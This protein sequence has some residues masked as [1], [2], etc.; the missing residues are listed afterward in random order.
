[1]L[2]G[3]AEA[4][5]KLLDTRRVDDRTLRLRFLP[6][7]LELLQ[8]WIHPTG[9]YDIALYTRLL[10]F[11][12]DEAGDGDEQYLVA[13]GRRTAEH[14]I[15]AAVYPEFE[16][17]RRLES[18]GRATAPERFVAFGRDL[19][20]LITVHETMLDFAPNQVIRDPEHADRYVIE[21]V[22]AAAY[23]EVLCWTTQGFCNRMAEEHGAPE[24]W[25]WQRPSRELVWYRMRRPL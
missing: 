8:G 11:L 15:R 25:Y 21:H 9:W 1:V 14:M 6:G 2:A 24:L 4:L 22:D 23:P 3:H 17:L 20:Q 10:E 12:R 13:A 18:S 19:R 16:F 7:E 5:V